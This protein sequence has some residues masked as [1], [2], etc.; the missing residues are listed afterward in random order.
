MSLQTESQTLC[1]QT[2][3]RAHTHTHAYLLQCI[4]AAAVYERMTDGCL[5]GMLGGDAWEQYPNELPLAYM[6]AD[7]NMHLLALDTPWPADSSHYSKRMHAKARRESFRDTKSGKHAA[8]RD[9]CDGGV[10][11][12]G[13]EGGE[14]EKEEEEVQSK[15]LASDAGDTRMDCVL[16]EAVSASVSADCS[17]DNDVDGERMGPEGAKDDELAP[18]AVKGR[19]LEAEDCVAGGSSTS[20]VRVE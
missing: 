19:Y 2:H 9:G 8:E 5:A 20:R 1:G 4:D 11:G 10:L 17:S 6:Q 18:Q 12:G 13:G 7:L 14:G 15:T 3:A 16:T